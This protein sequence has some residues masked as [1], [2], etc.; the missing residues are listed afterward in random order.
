MFGLY[1][2]SGAALGDV[3]VSG[4]SFVFNGV[5]AQS[6]TVGQAVVSVNN[7][8]GLVYTPSAPVIPNLQVFE[9]ENFA[10]PDVFTGS[11]RI[12]NAPVTINTDVTFN[13]NLGA[14]IVDSA[15]VTKQFNFTAN[16]VEAQNPTVG[17]ATVTENI[18]INFSDISTQ[19]PTISNLVF[20]YE[21]QIEPEITFG[22]PTVDTATINQFLNFNL[23]LTFGPLT[24]DRMRFKFSEINV[25]PKVYNQI[26]VPAKN[27]TEQID[28]S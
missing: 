8:M 7:E 6:P 22:S 26:T 24:V 12:D 23:S 13:F 20:Y 15:T 3:G 25:P 14:P 18:N 21:Y 16:D 4:L 28:A 17:N 27:Y 9:D 2:L 10:P 5:T 19:N 11:V 1:P